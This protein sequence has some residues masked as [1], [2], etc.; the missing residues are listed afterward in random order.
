MTDLDLVRVQLASAFV[1]DGNAR[2]V[3]VNDPGRSGAPKI[4]FAGCS[5]GNLCLFRRDVG[6][7][8]IAAIRSVFATES[9]LCRFDSRPLH[10]NRYVSLVPSDAP[11]VVSFGL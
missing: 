6:E 4:V 9:P 2:I 11:P 3:C 7:E 8:G 1:L 5:E 10:L